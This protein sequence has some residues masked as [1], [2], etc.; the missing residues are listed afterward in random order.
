MHLQE[1]PRLSATGPKT[2]WTA[3]RDSQTFCNDIMTVWQP[4]G[5][6]QTVRDGAR[7]SF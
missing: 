4:G 7:Q 2:V 5:N 1:T 6:S 3:A